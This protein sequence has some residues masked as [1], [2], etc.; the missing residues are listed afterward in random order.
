MRIGQFTDSFLPIVDGV[1]RVVYGYSNA[2]CKRGHE[3][4]VITPMSDAGY[5]GRYPFDIVDFYG[6]T[7]PEYT[8]YKMGIPLWDVHYHERI[9]SIKFDIAHVH[10]PF[11]SGFEG[12]RIARKMKIPVIGTFHSKYYED[13]L[14]V[15]KVQPLAEVG[16]KMVAD[17]YEKCDEVWAVSEN[18]AEALRSYGYK[19]AI[20]IMRNGTEIRKPDKKNII[21]VKSLYNL[22]NDP[23]ILFVGQMNWKKNILRVLEAVSLLK[24]QGYKTKLILAGQGPHVDEIKKK[25]AELDISDIVELAGH[26]TDIYI[27]D[28]LYGAADIFAFPS[29]YDNSPMV[30]REAAAMM[31]PSVLVKKSSAAEGIIDGQNGYLC[32]DDSKDL[33]DVFKKA[34]FQEKDKLNLVSR[35]AQT[36]I[37]V[38]WDNIMVDVEKRYFDLVSQRKSNKDRRKKILI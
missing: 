20:T 3:C 35:N 38:S 23:V 11:R 25:T 21:Y 16:V 18:S 36:T 4:Y 10:S 12:L 7:I 34:L 13:F 28:G 37:P 15:L 9:K 33:A 5:R 30:V 2:L 8:Q 31:T 14:Q 19:G 27:L 29:I 1:G 24:K 6:V 26:I 22:N 32:E 17:F